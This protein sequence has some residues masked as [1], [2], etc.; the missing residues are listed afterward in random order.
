MFISEGRFVWAYLGPGR[1][2]GWSSQLMTAVAWGKTLA[3]LL[4]SFEVLAKGTGA[5][6]R[7]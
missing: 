1:F 6:L 3:K 2:Y 7:P 5:L 4:E